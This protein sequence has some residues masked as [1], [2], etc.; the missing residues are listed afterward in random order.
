MR[1]SGWTV[2]YTS[3][4]VDRP[5]TGPSWLRELPDDLMS[6]LDEV[7][8]PDGLRFLLSP[9]VEYDVV[10]NSYFHRV[11]LI[12]APWNS[13]AN[14]A[15][16]LAGY[17]NFLHC[18]R[19]GKS[20]R[21]ATE[22]DHLA[23]H[24]W[25]RRDPAGPRV[26]GGTWSQEVA[27][28]NQFF[29]WAV[30]QNQLGAVPIPHRSRRPAP[31]GTFAGTPRARA[32][33][34][35][36]AT[37][38]HDEGGERIEWLPPASYR[39]WRDVGLRGYGAD[40]LP[41]G[42]FKGR[43][44][45]R[46]A[47]FTDLMVRTG[48]RLSEQSHLTTMEM[49]V[50]VGLGGY[51][52]F[53]L[54]GAIAK[55]FSARWIY[56]P[57][58]VVRDLA[59]YAELD[60]AEVVEDARTAGRYRRWR[61]P[62]VIDDP[63]RPQL[64]RVAGG[65]TRRVVNLRELKAMERRRLLVETSDG[66]EPALFWLGEDGQPLAVSTWKSVFADANARCRDQRIALSCHAH[67]LRRGFAVVTLEQLQRGHI[68]A[69]VELNE[70]QRGHYTRIFGDPLDWVRRRLGHRSVLTTAVYLHALQ[71]LEMETRMALVPD[72]WEDPRD[73]PL[74]RIGDDT[75]PPADTIEA[76]G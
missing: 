23:F 25:R 50:G 54:P 11:D 38:A 74:Q 31:L 1:R 30:R 18:A 29:E 19:G 59:A 65:G 13:N 71:E 39:L 52:R 4:D 33:E 22:A 3:R 26:A 44:S 37:Y 40:G 56:A 14:R 48:M 7:G 41:T 35:V 5:V 61:R 66:L 69:L 73:T 12:D 47:T 75:P 55:Y 6:W 34:T 24:Q 68:A 46:N 63:S 10:L 17:L 60:R 2:H 8:L 27:H 70:A 42:R 45:A 32:E 58:S 53:W 67:L 16:A 21:Q 28:V 76:A 15:R 20:W 72:S 49:P 51:Q 64:V 43:W 9:L 62:L 57:H 36:P